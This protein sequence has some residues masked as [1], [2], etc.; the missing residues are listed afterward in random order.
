MTDHRISKTVTGVERVMN[1]GDGLDDLVTAVSVADQR[2]KIQT[3]L[4]NLS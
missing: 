3:F 2:E 4:S 1:G